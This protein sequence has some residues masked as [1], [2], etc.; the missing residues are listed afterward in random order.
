MG[1]SE[2]S[3]NKTATLLLGHLKQ[4]E[5]GG[6]AAKV[7][8]TT[9]IH[10]PRVQDYV[11]ALE[12]L[13]LEDT[14]TTETTNTNTQEEKGDVHRRRHRGGLKVRVVAG[15]SG[16]QDFCFLLSA[17]KELVGSVTS[18]YVRWAAILGK[19]KVAKLYLH[20]THGLRKSVGIG[21]G[22]HHQDGRDD[23]DPL[24][25]LGFP[26]TNPTLQRR[27]QFPVYQSEYMERQQQQQQQQRRQQQRVDLNGK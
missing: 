8:I 1:L 15:Q 22:H 4:Q 17:E 14:T 6:A 2:L 13:E 20:D 24:Q 9:R 7:A 16:V 27:I 23:Q 19:A 10:N 25:V 5:V 11:H 3:P 12:E 26:W 21:I 18:T